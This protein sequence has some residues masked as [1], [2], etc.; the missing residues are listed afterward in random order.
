MT[1]NLGR[2]FHYRESSTLEHFSFSLLSLHM[3]DFLEY[4]TSLSS[5]S[6]IFNEDVLTEKKKSE[7][8]STGAK[9]GIGV[10]VVLAIWFFCSGQRRRQHQQPT[11][12]PAPPPQP[13]PPGPAPAPEPIYEPTPQGA[14]AMIQIGGRLIE[15]LIAYVVV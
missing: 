4:C 10:G 14:A 5:F 7:G 1:Y 3:E 9:V 8:L 12:A 11:P 13:A 2:I 6:L 15:N